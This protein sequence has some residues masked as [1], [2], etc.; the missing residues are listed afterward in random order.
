MAG[1]VTFNTFAYLGSLAAIHSGILS[2]RDLVG[3]APSRNATF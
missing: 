2:I 3:G 1:A